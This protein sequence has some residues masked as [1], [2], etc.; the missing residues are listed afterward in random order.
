MHI[1]TNETYTMEALLF[2][3]NYEKYKSF[4]N[5]GAEV[6]VTGKKSEDGKLLIDSI[7]LK[8]EEI[9]M[10]VVDETYNFNLEKF[11]A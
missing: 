6:F 3:K 2:P 8:H 5:E 10:P 7:S 1:V 9:S 11:I 4:L